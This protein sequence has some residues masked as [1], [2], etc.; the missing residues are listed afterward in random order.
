MTAPAAHEGHELEACCHI[1]VLL[2][3]LGV[4]ANILVFSSAASDRA[5]DRK[6]TA[7]RRLE[8]KKG[9]REK[10]VLSVHKGSGAI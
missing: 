10:K 4:S 2:K 8:K 9:Q 5:L 6:E 3:S 7:S 1:T